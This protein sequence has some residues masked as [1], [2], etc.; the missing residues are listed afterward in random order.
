MGLIK[1]FIN[2]FVFLA[3]ACVAGFNNNNNNN[4][5]TS[6]PTLLIMEAEEMNHC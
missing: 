5:K 3:W 6:F 4:D 1:Q 2:N